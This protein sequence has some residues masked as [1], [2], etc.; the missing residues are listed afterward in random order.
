MATRNAS[1]RSNTSRPRSAAEIADDLFSNKS[2]PDEG[3][4]REQLRRAV[5]KLFEICPSADV[6]CLHLIRDSDCTYLSIECAF[7]EAA[8]LVG[9][10]FLTLPPAR[11]RYYPALWLRTV[12]RTRN[13]RMSIIAMVSDEHR[14][15][16][17]GGLATFMPSEIRKLAP[18][19]PQSAR[20]W[21]DYVRGKL[22]SALERVDPESIEANIRR[23]IF[24][25]VIPRGGGQALQ[26]AI[27]AL[28]ARFRLRE[29][30][31]QH[32]VGLY[33]RLHGETLQAMLTALDAARV[34]DRSDTERVGPRL[35]FDNTTVRP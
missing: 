17:L 33:R 7:E 27:D 3:F 20:E 23:P 18:E 16:S 25:S 2:D 10:E 1:T 13:L 32:L 12:R 22:E 8:D 24:P 5:A 11:V 9:R 29:S 19:G 15:C 6:D 21:K 4:T 34:E 14:D 35:V 26:E 30:D 28:N 31:L